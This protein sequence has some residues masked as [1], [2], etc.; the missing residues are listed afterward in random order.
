[1]KTDTTGDVKIAACGE[2]LYVMSCPQEMDWQARL[3][4]V[5]AVKAASAGS[6][7]RG[8]VVDMSAVTFISSAGIGAIFALR[9]YLQGGG[10]RMAAT[11]A[12]VTV[13]RLLDTVMMS[14]LVPIVETVAEARELLASGGE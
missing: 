12:T 4:L 9:K 8:V 13:R 7:L 5:A 6:S 2:G 14:E 10:A 1:M 11:G 3:D